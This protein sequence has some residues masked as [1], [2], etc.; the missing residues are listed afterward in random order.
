M[1]LGRYLQRES[2]SFTYL[3]TFQTNQEV[4]RGISHCKLSV[5]SCEEA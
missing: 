2:V 1:K 3:V 4:N 5:N